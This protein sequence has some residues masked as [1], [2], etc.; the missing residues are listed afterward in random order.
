MSQSSAFEVATYA[1]I[2]ELPED[3]RLNNNT[4]H[5]NYELVTA[6][7]KGNHI[8]QPVMLS[9]TNNALSES[10]LVCYEIPPE[11]YES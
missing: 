10:S 6:S 4:D 8:S 5:H 7:S 3:T 11:E 2:P 9:T 1:D